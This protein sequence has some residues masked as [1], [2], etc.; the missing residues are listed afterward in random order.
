MEIKMFDDNYMEALFAEA[1]KENFKERVAEL[2][3]QPTQPLP[4]EFEERMQKIFALERRK[5]MLDAI[6]ITIRKATKI[7]AA[8]IAFVFIALGATLLT[9]PEVRAAVG[10][11]FVKWFNRCT[12]FEAK[13]SDSSFVKGRHFRPRFVPAGFLAASEVSDENTEVTTIFYQDANEKYLMFEYMPI[14]DSF[15]VNNEDAAYS[16]VIENGVTYHIFIS[17]KD[18]VLDSVVWEQAGYRFSLQGSVSVAI[19]FEMA[20]SVEKIN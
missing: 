16:S 17:L 1:V 6:K 13:P 5:N 2:E 3:A 12:K 10:D 11:T 9:A 7:S 14:N 4:V 19:L 20:K 15:S 18:G 8:C